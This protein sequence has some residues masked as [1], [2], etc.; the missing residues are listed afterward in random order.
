MTCPDFTIL[1]KFTLFTL[2]S[3]RVTKEL[4]LLTSQLDLKSFLHG[5]GGTEWIVLISCA[6]NA[7]FN[8]FSLC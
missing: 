7:Y 2:F 5:F 3:S 6:Q 1:L 4:L 8:L